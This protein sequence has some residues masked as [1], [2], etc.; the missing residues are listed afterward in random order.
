MM[1]TPAT[2]QAIG[3]HLIGPFAVSLLLF[4]LYR[5]FRSAYL[6]QWTLGFACLTLFH[7][8]VALLIIGNEETVNN[9]ASL[10]AASV[11]G[12][13]TA[14]LQLGGMIWGTFEL[15]RRKPLKMRDSQRLLVLLAAAGL[16]SGAIPFLLG[17]DP[18]VHRYFFLALHSLAASIVFV[19]C[20]IAV[21]RYRGS[22]FTVPSVALALY[23]LVQLYEF[24]LIMRSL[25]D[26][27][28]TTPL[29]AIGVSDAIASTVFALA[30]VLI[31]LEDQREVGI[32]ATS[33][34]EQL[35]YYDTLTGLPNRSLFADRLTVAIAHAH[36][37]RYKLAILFL[38]LDRFKQ[39]NDS[40]GHT[41]GDRLLKI[42]SSRIRT[43]IREEDTVARFGGDEFTVLIHIIGKIED[44]GKVAQ[45]ILDA[46]KA[47]ITIDDRD[48]V[49][50]SSVGISVYPNDGTDGETLIR[51]ADTAMYRA[52]DLGRNSCQYYAATM[53]HKA[54]E[55]L[56]VENGMRRALIQNEFVLHYQPLIDIGSGTVFGLE[57]LIRWQHPELGLLRP[58]RFIPAAEQTGLIIAIDRWVLREACQQASEWH[59]RGHNVVMAVNLS[60]RQFH[61]PDLIEQVREALR[62]ADLRPQFLEIEITEGY[63]MRDVEKAIQILQQLKALGVRISIDDFG[64]GYSCLSYLKDFPIDTLKLDGSFVRDLASPEDAQIALGVI[65]LAHSLKLKVIAEGVETISQLTFLREHDCDRLQGYLFSRPMPPANFD[66]FMNQKDVLRYA[67]N[68][69]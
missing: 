52:K 46:F 45:K 9:R 38:D 59:R 16:V 29:F 4:Q 61:D 55:A 13:A 50:T 15:A 7:I 23:G 36:R 11:A 5:K 25:I 56:E 22:G 35:A 24:V 12:A 69:H 60:G 67:R 27:S 28:T 63:A 54:L 32:E 30:A 53:N 47:P 37:H 41:V 68:S 20:G 51:N 44:A 14:Y 19:G 18:A 34:V 57:A 66:R 39:I 58:D 33:Q 40:L 3:L 62:L 26:R 10:I 21:R 31:I 64:T 6:V 2:F 1:P 17:H 65:A 49:V 43:T 8:S 48:F 42:V